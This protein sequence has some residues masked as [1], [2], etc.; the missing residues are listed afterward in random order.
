MS[1]SPPSSPPAGYSVTSG[2]CHGGCA[3]RP[4][5]PQPGEVWAVHRSESSPSPRAKAQWAP[6][7]TQHRPRRWPGL[8]PPAPTC[9]PHSQVLV[10]FLP[11]LLEAPLGSSLEVLKTIFKVLVLR[12][13]QLWERDGEGR[14]RERLGRA[15]GLA[16]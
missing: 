6:S 13:V 3:V 15:V 1:P 16:G 11:Q 8:S 14:G 5:R 4:R 10:H 12:E 9:R 7:R 2:P